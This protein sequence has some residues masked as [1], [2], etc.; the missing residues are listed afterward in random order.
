M[1]ARRIRTFKLMDISIVLAVNSI[2]AAVV[3]CPGALT[4][5]VTS[6]FNIP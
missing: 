1:S 5:V 6:V 3:F 2:I 4:S